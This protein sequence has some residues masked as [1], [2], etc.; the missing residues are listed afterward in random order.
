MTHV[1]IG[2]IIKATGTPKYCFKIYANQDDINKLKA[3]V[4]ATFVE[5]SYD[6]EI[7]HA[8]YDEEKEE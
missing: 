7:E 4:I 6:M 1:T 2:G 8:Y 5:E 3:L